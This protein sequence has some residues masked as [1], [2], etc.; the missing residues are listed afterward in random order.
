MANK[1]RAG[2]EDAS[3]AESYEESTP[4]VKRARVEDASE[5]GLSQPKRRAKD[6]KKQRKRVPNDDEMELDDNLNDLDL[7]NI[8]VE[9]DEAFE[10]THGEKLEKKVK[11]SK[12]NAGIRPMGIIEAIEMNNFMCHGRLSFQFG[13]QINFIIGNNGSG[14]S[15]VLSALTVALGGKANLTGRGSG[16]KSFIKEDVEKA[17]QR[18]AKIEEKIAEVESSQVNFESVAATVDQ[19]TA[20]KDAIPRVDDI[21]TELSAVKASITKNKDDIRECRT[22]EKSINAQVAAAKTSISSLEAEIRKRAEEQG[23]VQAERDRNQQALQDANA[24]LDGAEEELREIQHQPGHL[25]RMV[26]DVETEGRKISDDIK[27]TRDDIT[28]I[29]ASLEQFK[30][31]DGDDLRLFG[32]NIAQVID[33]VQNQQWSGKM[34]VGPFGLYVANKDPQW[35]MVMRAQLGT[36]MSSWAVTNNNDRNKLKQIL[37]RFGNHQVSIT[38]SDV[39]LFDYSRGEP[40]E[41]ILTVLRAL[42]I[43]DEWVKRI[44]INQRS[45]EKVVLA[46]T[47]K[48]G[49]QILQQLRGNGFAWTADG[50]IVRRYAE[51]GGSNTP[52]PTVKHQ[53]PRNHMFSSSDRSADIRRCE[54]DKASAEQR[55]QEYMASQKALSS[56]YRGLQKEHVDAKNRDKQLRSRIQDLK[57]KIAKLHAAA[58][59][60]SSVNVDYLVESKTSQEEELR[61]L[62]ENFRK[63]CERKQ[64]LEDANLPLV[65]KKEELEEKLNNH[66]TE[67]QTIKN[68]LA[69]AL[70]KRVE[71]TK[72]KKHYQDKL[73]EEETKL[74][75]LEQ[76]SSL[77]Q[78]EFEAWS[79]QAEQIGE[80]FEKPRKPENVQRQIDSVQKA[81]KQHEREQGASPEEI[82]IERDNAWL[83]LENHKRQCSEIQRLNNAL[84]NSLGLRMSKWVAFRQHIALRCKYQFQ[85]HLWTRGY[86]GK[87][88]FDHNAGTLN[89]KVQTEDQAGT[90][91]A[92]KDPK[93]LSGGEK[94]YSTICLLLALWESIQCPIR[95]LGMSLDVLHMEKLTHVYVDEF[96]VFM[97]AANR[98]I[99]MKMMIETANTSDKQYILITPQDMSFLDFGESVRVHRMSN[100]LACLPYY[101]ATNRFSALTD[102]PERNQGSLNFGN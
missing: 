90:Q 16:L 50:N 59:E 11:A 33:T 22:D 2:S 76:M 6:A 13:P 77:V 52:M 80:R 61:N 69:A 49:D 74:A 3:D 46:K 9:D 85:H 78:T 75:E 12:R 73:A 53:D 45:I 65:T 54:D 63:V 88:I 26:Q 27:R 93:A 41:D 56:K 19:I 1:R 28:G 10:A 17:K 95:C 29:E 25:A 51:G 21:R 8:T 4:S 82:A 71:A 14:K 68:R 62:Q 87:V 35:V 101:T 39:D 92:D 98:R 7:T 70:G 99:S 89:L 48:E 34:P 37:E 15:A 38:I 86:Y 23:D 97:D 44:L 42:E 84:K 83:A 57:M 100:Y 36:N 72:H 91:A 102:D 79:E 18:K 32:N 94:S 58:V 40:P 66:E 43:K 55:L 20:E 5:E 24:D 60:E 31:K 30:R 67:M 96:D 47:R 81:L 64:G